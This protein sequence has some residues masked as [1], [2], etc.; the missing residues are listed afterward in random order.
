[1][2]YYGD[3]N[4]PPCT[5]NSLTN[6]DLLIKPFFSFLNKALRN[7]CWGVKGLGIV[8]LL[9]NMSGRGLTAFLSNRLLDFVKR[10]SLMFR[11]LSL[12]G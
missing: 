3:C 9:G 8:G 7:D 1:M 11:H 2:I 4:T 6:K 12:R 5:Q 10:D